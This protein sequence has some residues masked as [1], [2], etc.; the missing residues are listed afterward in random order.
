MPFTPVKLQFCIVVGS[1]I[2]LWLLLSASKMPS[3]GVALKA[4]TGFDVAAQS[5]FRYFRES[6]PQYSM[7]PL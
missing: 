2:W 7:L 6:P 3:A 5:K 1:V 4:N